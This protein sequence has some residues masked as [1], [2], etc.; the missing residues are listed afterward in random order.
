MS[1]IFGLKKSKG[2]R[3]IT[4]LKKRFKELEG[5]SLEVGFFSQNGTHPSGLTYTNLFA[6]Q[7][8][9]SKA[10]GIP[11]RPVLDLNFQLWNPVSSNKLIKKQL[12]LF[13][14][15]INSPTPPIKFS[16]VLDNIAGSYVQST[17]TVFGDSTLLTVN[18][19]STVQYKGKQSP[20]VETGHLRDNLSYTTTYK[21]LSIVTP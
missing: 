5:K 12:K 9:G 17:R 18:A 19:S 15:N 3:A 6:I 2:N 13:F 21:G 20:L 11:K 1:L 8:F 14:S 7:S 10:V 4:N 16:K